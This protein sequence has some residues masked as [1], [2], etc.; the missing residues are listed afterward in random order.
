MNTVVCPHCGKK[1]EISEALRTQIED[2]LLSNEREEHAKALKDVALKAE[3]K[4]QKKLSEQFE[5]Q[6]QRAKEDATDKDE[7]IKQL[8]T[9]LTELSDEMRKIRREKDEVALDMKKKL[10]EEE[11]KIREDATTK[12]LAEQHS[13]LAEKDK[14][15]QDALKETEGLKRKLEQGSQQTQ[16]EAFE[17]EFEKLLA[18]TFP[19]DKILPVGKGIRGGDVIQE[20]WDSKGNYSGKILWELKNTKNWQEPWID[21]LKADKRAINAEEAVIISEI[22]PT[23]LK[24]AE[25]GGAHV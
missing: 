19:N 3:E 18:S 16:G 14:Q 24:V 2:E 13:K 15:L 1:V 6:I 12:A 5:L 8:I 20:V 17:L 23:D 25:I 9:Q 4:V 7:R 10:A 22:L 21:K 11:E